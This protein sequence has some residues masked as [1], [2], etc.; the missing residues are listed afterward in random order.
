VLRINRFNGFDE[1]LIMRWNLTM[2][3]LVLGLLAAGCTDTAHD[4]GPPKPA[5]SAPAPVLNEKEAEIQAERAKLS[6]ED[7]ALVEAQEWCAVD[8]KER[9]GEMDAPFKLMIKGKPVFLCCEGCRK[10]AEADPDKTLATVEEL[11][12]KKKAMNK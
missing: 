1:E 7:R 9:L 12:A 4:H 6:P 11:K 10:K 5:T 2:S 8:N 3:A